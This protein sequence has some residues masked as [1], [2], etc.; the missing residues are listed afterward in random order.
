MPDLLAF[1]IA[2][3]LGVFAL[4]AFWECDLQRRER[5]QRRQAEQWVREK[6]PKVY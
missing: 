2:V 5:R 4:A 1:L 3:G 6:Y